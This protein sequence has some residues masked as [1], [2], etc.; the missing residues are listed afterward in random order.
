MKCT[1]VPGFITS[2]AIPNTVKCELLRHTESFQTRIFEYKLSGWYF[3]R[4]VF[5]TI[6]PPATC[7]TLYLESMKL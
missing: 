4:N 5:S 6:Y 3:L 2:L 1:I 7:H